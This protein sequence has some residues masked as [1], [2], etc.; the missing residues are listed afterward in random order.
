MLRPRL[1]RRM[2]GLPRIRSFRLRHLDL[3]SEKLLHVVSHFMG[4]HLGFGELRSTDMVASSLAAKKGSSPHDR[5]LIGS[6]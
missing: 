2:V 5:S 3:D 6:L 4:Q 1:A